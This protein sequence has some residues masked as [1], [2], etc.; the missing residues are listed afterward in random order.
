MDTGGPWGVR[1]EMRQY[2]GTQPFWGP[3]HAELLAGSSLPGAAEAAGRWRA[4]L[5]AVPKM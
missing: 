4:Q 2:S 5:T 1:G 3:S